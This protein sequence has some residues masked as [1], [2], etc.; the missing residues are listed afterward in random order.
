[1]R[2]KILIANSVGRDEAGNNYILFP[3]RWTASV[4]KVKS[5]E[6]YPYE[7]AY[8]SSMLK[9]DGRFEVKMVDGNLEKLNWCEYF[10]KYENEKP[11]YLVMESSSVVYGDDL[12]FA[13]EF[14]KKYGTRLIF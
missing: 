13:L 10:K 6:F 12:R 11:D 1:M 3:S 14:K 2:K 9:R 8:L 7:L 5:F 4:G